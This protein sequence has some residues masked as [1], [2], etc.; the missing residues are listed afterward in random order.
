MAVCICRRTIVVH[1]QLA[2]NSMNHSNPKVYCAKMHALIGWHWCSKITL[3]LCHFLSSSCVSAWAPS[4]LAS[5]Y[6]DHEWKAFEEHHCG[7]K[8]CKFMLTLVM[9]VVAIAINHSTIYGWCLPVVDLVI[10]SVQSMLKPVD[11]IQFDS[12]TLDARHLIMAVSPNTS[13]EANEQGEVPWRQ[14]AGGFLKHDVP[15]TEGESRGK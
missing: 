13:L 5:C 10:T 7:S 9:L 11:A 3:D 1:V 12:N 15:A 4:W 8:I 2:Q 14:Q 6:Q